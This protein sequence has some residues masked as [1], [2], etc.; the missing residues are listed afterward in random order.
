MPST[1]SMCPR[2]TE[3][4]DMRITWTKFSFRKTN[5]L[6]VN[7]TGVTHPYTRGD[8]LDH[9]NKTVPASLFFI[10]GIHCSPIRERTRHGL[11]D[12]YP[13]FVQAGNFPIFS[14]AM[15]TVRCTVFLFYGLTNAQGN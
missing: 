3:N 15:Y 8:R 10:C 9:T 11:R 6:R 1:S 7:C 13:P 4:A 2:S 14:T 5:L 12:L